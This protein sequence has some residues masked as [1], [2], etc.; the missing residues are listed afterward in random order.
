MHWRPV[1]LG[2][3]QTAHPSR[4]FGSVWS[5]D[6]FLCT[7]EF[8][9]ISLA[10][11]A[12]WCFAS[13][14]WL[15]KLFKVF[16]IGPNW[17]EINSLIGSLKLDA[18]NLLESL[19]KLAWV[20]LLFKPF[21]VCLL[22]IKGLFKVLFNKALLKSHGSFRWDIPLFTFTLFWATRACANGILLNK[23]VN[24]FCTFGSCCTVFT[25]DIVAL[26]ICSLS[27]QTLSAIACNSSK[28]SCSNVCPGL[29]PIFMV[30]TTAGFIYLM[31]H[32]FTSSSVTWGCLSSVLASSDSF[33]ASRKLEIQST[34]SPAPWLNKASSCKREASLSSTSGVRNC[35]IK[36]C[37][38]WL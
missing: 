17:S 6:L 30:L 10:I 28:V 2:L 25:L 4:V 35:A 20:I 22:S 33:L 32:L 23:L 37:L 16:F 36:C 26:F 21:K 5:R 29:K 24:G 12:I 38:A 27:R 14:T 13:K 31:K 9:L 7:L 15:L 34:I 19:I 3:P 18:I 11:L 1:W 8:S